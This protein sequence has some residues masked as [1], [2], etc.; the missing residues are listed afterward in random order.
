MSDLSMQSTIGLLNPA[1]SWAPR[2]SPRRKHGATATINTFGAVNISSDSEKGD[3]RTHQR[4]EKMWTPTEKSY[5]S[6]QRPGDGVCPAVPF[7][8]PRNPAG[9]KSVVP[10]YGSMPSRPMDSGSVYMQSYSPRGVSTPGST[11]TSARDRPLRADPRSA[12]QVVDLDSYIPRKD[13]PRHLESRIS[14]L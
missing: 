12:R 5:H 7:G 4:H 8:A 1:A 14:G 9:Y 6:C 2:P 10:P 11:R 3:S 13:L